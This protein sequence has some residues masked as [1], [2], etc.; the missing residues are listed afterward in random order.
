[1]LKSKCEWNA[2]DHMA[3]E[4]E[5]LFCFFFFQFG[6][7][8]PLSHVQGC[9]LPIIAFVGNDAIHCT[10]QN[11]CPVPLYV[12]NV[13]T[14]IVCLIANCPIVAKNITNTLVYASTT[15]FYKKEYLMCSNRYSVFVR[16]ILTN[17]CQFKIY[18][19]RMSTTFHNCGIIKFCCK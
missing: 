7:V 13:C 3:Y 6:V 18:N 16:R 15:T 8:S 12:Y 19:D 10:H 11:A 9:L 14:Y 1:M 2:F 17:F 4:R 5:N